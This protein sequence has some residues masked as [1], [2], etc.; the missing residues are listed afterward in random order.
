MLVLTRKTGQEIVLGGDIRVTLTVAGDRVK[1]G[2]AAPPAV[3]VRRAEM[4]AR[5][6]CP[7]PPPTAHPTSP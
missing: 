1:V 5:D 6:G 3:R 4:A 7:M 2:I